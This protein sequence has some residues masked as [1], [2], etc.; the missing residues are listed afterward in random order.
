MPSANLDLVRLLFAAWE[1]G[2]FGSAAWADPEIELVI[3]DG[4]Q[5]GSWTGIAGMADGWR[6][7]LSTWEA[8]Y[9]TEAE[10]YREL[11][12]GRILVTNYYIGR[13][14]TSGLEVGQ[15]R[16]K[17][18]TIFQFHHRKVT[19]LALYFDYKRALADLGLPEE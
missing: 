8:G 12:G 19:R 14:K 6:D 2:E 1:Q 7:F 11:D 13:G 17:G 15:I 4:P 18:A 3:A 5:P 16:A 10:E 9:R